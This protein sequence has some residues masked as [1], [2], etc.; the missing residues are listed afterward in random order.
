MNDL[1]AIKATCEKDIPANMPA[2]VK[3]TTLAP[4]EMMSWWELGEIIAHVSVDVLSSLYIYNSG[5]RQRREFHIKGFAR[6]KD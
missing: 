5:Q 4:T 6:N 2:E 1:A 3:P